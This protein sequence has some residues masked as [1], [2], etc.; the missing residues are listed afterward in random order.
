MDEELKILGR[1]EQMFKSKPSKS[2]VMDFWMSLSVRDCECLINFFEQNKP[3][4]MS[5]EMRMELIKIFK[6]LKAKLIEL[7][8][9]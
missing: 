1:L 6:K 8:R 5:D 2:D 4:G 3:E 9:V 7:K